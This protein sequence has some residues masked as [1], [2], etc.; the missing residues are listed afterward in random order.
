MN[1]RRVALVTGGTSG[2]GRSLVWALAREGACVAICGRREDALAHTAHAARSFGGDALA[3][4][5]DVRDAQSADDAVRAAIDQWGRLDLALLS[6]GVA[7]GQKPDEFTADVVAE[8]LAVNVVGVAHGMEACFRAMRAQDG[9]GTIAVISS[10]ASDRALTGRGAAYS[11]S[12][13]A[14]SHLCDGVRAA[15]AED[16]VRLVNVCPGFIRTPMTAENGY[17][18]LLMEPEEAAAIILSGIRRGRSVI[19]FPLGASLGMGA[20]RLLP[21]AAIDLIYRATPTDRR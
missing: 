11:A 7:I 3:I 8:T 4:R 21:A 16:G 6:A 9:G 17:M 19:R 1:S 18:P 14:V 20:L 12:K 10:L 13:A 2:I 5:M 15:W